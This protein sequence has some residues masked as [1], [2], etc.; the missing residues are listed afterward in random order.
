LLP[1]PIN[2][3]ILIGKVEIMLRK[4]LVFCLSVYFIIPV[5]VVRAQEDYRLGPEDEIEI[6]V[7]SH[8]DLTRKVRVGLNGTISFPLTGEIKA[9]GLSIQELQKGIEQRLGPK[10]I[11]DPH[12]SISVTEFKSQKFFVVGN[13]QKPG[14]YPLTKPI[15]VIEAISL[16]GGIASGSGSRPL[17]G[18]VAIV[19]RAKQ[20]EK[21]DEPRMPDKT[22]ESQKAT[23][24]LSEALAGDPKKNIEIKHGD[25]IYVPNF[26]YYVTGEVK[27]PNRYPFEEN[28]T[29]LMAVTTAGGFTDKA[30]R[31][32]T[33]IIREVSGVKE[34]TKVTLDDLIRPGDTIV[35]PESWF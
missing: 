5:G 9:Q 26:L 15:K 32:G 16:A 33:Y 3:P 31:R 11:I 23:V 13:V 8:D 1:L 24:S 29:V 18:A 20:G 10:Y 2:S 7:W 35:V 17:S 6:Q 25:T 21:L 34:K 19:I 14:T 22:P 27:I 28:M 12:V 4:I 30:S